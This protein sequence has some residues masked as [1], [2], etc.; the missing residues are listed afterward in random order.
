MIPIFE[1]GNGRGLGLGLDTFEARF[2]DICKEHLK[3]KRAKS[4]AF[5]FYDFTDNA[6]RKILKDGG[7]FTQLDRLSGKDLSIFYLHGS[8]RQTAEEFN[9]TFLQAVGLA[10]TISLPCGGFLSVIR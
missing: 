8:H 6:L 3:H 7:L 1:Q 9:K 2:E 10:D 4:F 5:I